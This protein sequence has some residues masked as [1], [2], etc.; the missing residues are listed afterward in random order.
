MIRS[1]NTLSLRV[2]YFILTNG[3]VIFLC[4]KPG[5]LK[6]G[7]IKNPKEKMVQMIEVFYFQP[8]LNL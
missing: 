1:R 7:L 3:R 4:I 6:Y 2:K 5:N 8:I